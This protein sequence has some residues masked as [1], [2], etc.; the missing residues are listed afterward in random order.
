MRGTRPYL[1]LRSVGLYSVQYIVVLQRVVQPMSIP[2]QRLDRIP[3]PQ[4]LNHSDF[5]RM[6]RGP[7]IEGCHGLVR[8]VLFAVA[9]PS[10]V[11]RTASAFCEK[12]A[13]R[14]NDSA[15]MSSLHEVTD[16]PAAVS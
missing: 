13:R 14:T 11:E 2:R 6:L 15:G 16:F 1:E 5:L 8:V 3:T 9:P 4:L 10:G 7:L 12:H